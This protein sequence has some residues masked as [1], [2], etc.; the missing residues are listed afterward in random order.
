MDKSSMK[1]VFFAVLLIFVAGETSNMIA[2]G[3]SAN[4]FI[5]CFCAPP[6]IC[7]GPFGSCTGCAKDS[8]LTSHPT[9]V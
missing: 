9:N 4:Q 5:P 8:P 2:E 7:H 1:L 6:C 3:R